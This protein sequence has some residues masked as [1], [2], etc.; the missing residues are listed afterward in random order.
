MP[1]PH[2]GHFEQGTYMVG[3]DLATGKDVTK[4]TL[5]DEHGNLTFMDPPPPGVALVIDER[6]VP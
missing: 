1:V 2:L 4:L 6:P 3:V 5:R